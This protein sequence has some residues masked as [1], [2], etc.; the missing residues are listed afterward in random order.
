MSSPLVKKARRT[1]P[2]GTVPKLRNGVRFGMN[3]RRG[4]RKIA[5]EN[6]APPALVF[7]LAGALDRWNMKLRIFH[8]KQL[9][10]LRQGARIGGQYWPAMIEIQ[11]PNEAGDQQEHGE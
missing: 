2:L 4:R 7:G 3:G 9:R 8:G 11:K 1:V 6:V 5:T 10:I